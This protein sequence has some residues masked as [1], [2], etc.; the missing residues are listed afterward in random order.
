MTSKHPILKLACPQAIII[1]NSC[2]TYR[3][4]TTFN[5][6]ESCEKK[7]SKSQRATSLPSLHNHRNTYSYLQKKPQPYRINLSGALHSNS[8]DMALSYSN[9]AKQAHRSYQSVLNFPNISEKS[10][11]EQPWGLSSLACNGA[12]TEHKGGENIWPC[13]AYKIRR[14]R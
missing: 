4:W 13:G 6:Y 11:S 1:L 9:K 10:I 5:K 8:V 12:W 2:H 7:K 14:I 3:I